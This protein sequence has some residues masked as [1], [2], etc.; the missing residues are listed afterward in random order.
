[1]LGFAWDSFLHEN[2]TKDAKNSDEIA[3]RFFKVFLIDYSL[4][5]YATGILPKNTKLIADFQN[6]NLT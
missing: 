6:V 2:K 5:I 3:I 4:K 1:M